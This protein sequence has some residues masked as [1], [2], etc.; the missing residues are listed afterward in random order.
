MSIQPP[1][2]LIL[3]VARAADPTR[4][5]A[6]VQKLNAAASGATDMTASDFAEALEQTEG[7]G[8]PRPSLL[9]ARMPDRLPVGFDPSG[10]LET[11]F[12]AML[13]TN[14]IQEMMPK[15]AADAFGGGMAG[16]MWKSMLSEKMADQLAQSGALGL[17]RRLFSAHNSSSAAALLRP[18]SANE[19]EHPGVVAMSANDL[20]LPMNVATP[21]DS[22][23]FARGRAI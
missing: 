12:E 2:D 3:D 18:G 17:S 20:S 7:V 14:M 1:S 22:Y 4:A 6:V 19:A 15:D 21:G 16:D 10:K 13:L 8:R 5:T 23:L 11:K 9:T